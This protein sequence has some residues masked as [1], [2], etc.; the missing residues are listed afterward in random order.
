LQSSPN[1]DRRGVLYAFLAYGT[2]GLFPMYWKWF[3]SI[4]A[5]EILSHRIIWSGVLL[6][7]ILTIRQRFWELWTF[8][9]VTRH[10]LPL[11]GTATLLAGNWGLY[12]YG[13]NSDRVIETSLGYFINPLVNVLLGVIILREK[14]NGGQWLAVLFATVGVGYSVFSVGQVPWIALSLAVSFGLYGLFRKMITVQPVVGL[15]VEACLLMPVAIAYLIYLSTQD[16]NHFGQG[17]LVTL[18]F[19][20]C[21]I[22]TSFP[23]FCF[24]TAAQHLRLSTLGFFQYLAPSLQLLLGVWLYR[25]PFTANHGVTFGLIWLALAVYSTTSW[26]KTRHLDT[27]ANPKI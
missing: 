10:W 12:I 13:V 22:V 3:G 18:L 2:W 6:V 17:S 9:A 14:L 1:S 26:L 21:G 16:T 7:L 23:L 4:P 5:P 20:G 8:V 19:I 15:A 11:L 25:E 27:A 24:T